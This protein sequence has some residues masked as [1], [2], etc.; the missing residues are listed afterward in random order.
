MSGVAY[1]R[2]HWYDNHFWMVRSYMGHAQQI[3]ITSTIA[4]AIC[5]GV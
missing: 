4:Q 5:L 3:G 1:G 2:D